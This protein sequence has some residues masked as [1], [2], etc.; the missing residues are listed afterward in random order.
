MVEG[1][2]DLAF[3]EAALFLDHQDA[4]LAAGKFAKTLGLQRPGHADLVDRELWMT[5][6][7]Q[8]AQ[9]VHRIFMRL[10]NG[11]QADR[12][13]GRTADQAVDAIGT[14]PGEHSR[15]PFLNH[16]AFKFRAIGR[17]MQRRVEIQ[18]M[19][20]QGEIRRDKGA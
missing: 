17:K 12:G 3:N 14:R 8:T 1:I 4:A 15:H 11:D 6:E 10:A 16:A 18:P 5:I 13:V 19:R 9:G 7:P 20:R 2:A